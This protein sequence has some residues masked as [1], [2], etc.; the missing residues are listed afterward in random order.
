MNTVVGFTEDSLR[1][2]NSCSKIF[3]ISIGTVDNDHD[4]NYYRIIMIMMY[5]NNNQI[6]YTNSNINDDNDENRTFQQDNYGLVFTT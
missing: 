3:A 1:T 2:E 4:Y 5:S 6:N